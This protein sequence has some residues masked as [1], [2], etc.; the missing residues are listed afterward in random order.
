MKMQWG[1]TVAKAF[2]SGKLENQANL[3]RYMA[4]YRKENAPELYEEMM[5]V[6]LE[7]RDYLSELQLLKAD[8][9]QDIREQIMSVEGRAAQRYWATVGRLIP[10]EFQW[11]GRETRGARDPLNSLLNYGYGILYGQVEQAITLA[12]LDPY[13]GF[14]HADRAGKPSLV[15]DLIEEFRQTVVDRT[16]I[17]LVNKHFTIEQDEEGRLNEVT[18]KKIAEKIL[19]RMESSETY[20]KS[21]RRSALFFKA[22][23]ATLRSMR[24]RARTVLGICIRMVGVQSACVISSSMIF[25]TMVHE[26]RL[27]MSAWIM[28][29]SAFNIVPSWVN[30]VTFTNANSCSKLNA[31]LESMEQIYSSFRLTKRGVARRLIQREKKE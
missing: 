21:G 8:K 10:S 1:I 30:L 29:Y 26:Q 12:G 5:L 18:R 17:G 7:M 19:E 6:A 25:L 14:L 15:L 23:H 22:R 9:I 4:K 31:V 3:L 16:I 13:A 28:V 20:E 2:I 11:P 24:W 27:P